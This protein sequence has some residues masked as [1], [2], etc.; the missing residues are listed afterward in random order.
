MNLRRILFALFLVTLLTNVSAGE[1]GATEV[2]E[3]HR[4]EADAT[5][6][7]FVAPTGDDSAAGTRAAPLKT[8]ASYDDMIG[9]NVKLPTLSDHPTSNVVRTIP[10]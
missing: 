10:D 3:T 1:A 8:I 2:A 7:L 4:R 5:K 9:K 6:T